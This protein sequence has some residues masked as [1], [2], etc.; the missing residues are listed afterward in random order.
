MPP[1]SVE[2][3]IHPPDSSYPLYLTAKRYF[4]PDS[5]SDGWTLFLLH[6]TSS[7]KESWEPTIQKIFDLYTRNKGKQKRGI[8]LRE[9]W[10]L[11][12]PNHGE[13]GQLN[14][15]ILQQ[16]EW[17]L[18]FSCEKY[19]QAVHH[20][21][22]AGPVDF[23]AR[24]LAGIGHSLG[25]NAISLLQSLASASLKNAF[26]SLIIIEPMLSPAGPEHLKKLRL[27]LIKGA[28]ER[29]D[30]WPDR[31]MAMAGL[32]KRDRTIKWDPRILEIFVKY[33]LRAH[34]GSFYSVSPY[35]GVTL[36]CTRDQEA[37]MYRD[38]DGATTPVVPLTQACKEKP[39]H[40]ILGGVHDFM[41]KR[42][43]DALL[44]PK[45]GRTFASVTILPDVGHLVPLEVPDRLGEV[46]FDALVKNETLIPSETGVK[47]KL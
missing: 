24:K 10:C 16:E 47:A 41:P 43:Q 40:L 15:R 35:P 11:D 30:V 4:V 28:Y 46:I 33:G 37:A 19:A 44:D 14:E 12:C 39:V 36:A 17:Y 27:A 26:K 34:P 18:N 29:R 38:P 31:T 23:S 3:I 45:S 8:K 42:T 13:G 1:L 5:D 2:S 32:K 9:A 20:F 6:A 21:L 25:G 7:H 22:T